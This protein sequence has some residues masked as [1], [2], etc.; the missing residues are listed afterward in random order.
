MRG[1]R[2]GF[3]GERAILRVEK[4]REAILRFCDFD[5]TRLIKNNLGTETD[6]ILREEK[7]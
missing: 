3:A 1:G 7:R 6:A 2:I 4:R 5:Y